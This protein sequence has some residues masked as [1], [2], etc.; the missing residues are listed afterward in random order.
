MVFRAAASFSG[1]KASLEV[2]QNF[3]TWKL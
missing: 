2:P 1:E 3:Q